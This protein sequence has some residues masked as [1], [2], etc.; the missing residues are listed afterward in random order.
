MSI[1]VDAG[2]FPFVVVRFLG[3]YSDEEFSAYLEQVEQLVQAGETYAMIFDARRAG[4][5]TSKQAREQADFLRRLGPDMAKVSVGSAFVI[6]SPLI[7]GAFKA[8]TW[9][10]S[11][12]VEHVVV[13]R[14]EQA[15]AWARTRL[16]A[17]GVEV[18]DDLVLSSSD[19]AS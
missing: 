4:M 12:P 14:M 2:P 11:M 8:I 17:A 13:E 7:R 19:A 10:Q 5:P 3:K 6:A 9:M 18:P 16:E 15:E 1:Q